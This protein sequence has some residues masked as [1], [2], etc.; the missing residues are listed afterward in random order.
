MNDIDDLNYNNNVI[1]PLSDENYHNPRR[2]NEYIANTQLMKSLSIEQKFPIDID[3]KRLTETASYLKEVDLSQFIVKKD[4]KQNNKDDKTLVR[5]LADPQKA[6]AIPKDNFEMLNKLTEKR[7]KKHD[8]YVKD[9][10]DMFYNMC[11]EVEKIVLES[12]REVRDKMANIDTEIAQIFVYLN[13]DSY[14]LKKN[15][16]EIKEMWNDIENKC[17]ERKQIII[18]YCDNLDNIEEKRGND[19][20][21]KLKQLI[22]DLTEVGHKLVPEIHEFVEELSNEANMII[23]NNMKDFADIRERLLKEDLSLYITSKSNYEK[24]EAEYRVLIHNEYIKRFLNEIAPDVIV[25]SDERKK[26]IEEM[27]ISQ[28]NIHVNN[29]MPLLEKIKKANV[30]E[31]ND[32][33][34]RNITNESEEIREKEDEMNENYFNKLQELS[35]NVNHMIHEKKEQLRFTLHSLEAY[36][37]NGELKYCHDKLSKII[38]SPDLEEFFRTSGG[39]HKELIYLCD[40]CGSDKMIYEEDRKTVSGRLVLP[41]NCLD[42]NK[43]FEEAG[44][45]SDKQQCITIL[46]KIKSVQRV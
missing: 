12:S 27:R 41:I 32:E 16:S 42:L 4:S 26:I 43:L 2:P 10:T 35:D 34:I 7:S 3:K 8:K 38:N 14:V 19:V 25:N 5:S 39:L 24:R 11:D 21:E 36:A 45:I 31:I 17:K 29:R 13:D 40:E 15:P 18:D 6:I 9:F 37:K 23:L 44:L 30:D 46:N 33:F 1:T 28:N 22:V 20:K